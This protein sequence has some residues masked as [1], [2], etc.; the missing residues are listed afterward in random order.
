M[1]WYCINCGNQVEADLM[2]PACGVCSGE[3]RADRRV[4]PDRR[5]FEP[6]LPA[7]GSTPSDEWIAVYQPRDA[8]EAD[9]VQ[10]YLENNG[11]PA[12]QMP[13]IADWIA[14]LEPEEQEAI[15][16]V[17]VPRGRAAEAR[18]ILEALSV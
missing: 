8:A 6:D 1:H 13:G 14:S 2:P 7:M 9:A 15:V 3:L 18:G 5:I 16:H 10:E 4:L 17:A 12:L 11:V